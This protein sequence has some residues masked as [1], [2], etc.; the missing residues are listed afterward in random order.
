M[1]SFWKLG[2]LLAACACAS[3]N[4]CSNGVSGPAA[5]LVIDNAR[6]WTVDADQPTAEAL[7]VLGERI[8]AV[9]SSSEVASWRGVNTRVVDAR[10]R[11]VL[12]G[13]NDSHVHLV[14]AGE[15]L[16]NVHLKDAES[17]ETFALRIGEFAASLPDGGRI[18][19]E[20]KN[21]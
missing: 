15:Q 2:L 8:V 7:A 19:Y 10:G 5:D 20:R 14:Q 3:S 21:Q 18:V 4:A 9:G 17:P 12:P 16:A 11:R 6:I 1:M 13:F